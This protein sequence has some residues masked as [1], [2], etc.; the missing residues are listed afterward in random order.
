MLR[1]VLPMTSATGMLT[2][3]LHSSRLSMEMAEKSS[4]L[5]G[6]AEQTLPGSQVSSFTNERMVECSGGFGSFLD[7]VQ[8]ESLWKSDPR[9]FPCACFSLLSDSKIWL[10]FSWFDALFSRKNATR[11]YLWL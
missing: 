6:D 9:I 10:C 8:I 3:N 5:K 11:N 2:R 7:L 1:V 4:D